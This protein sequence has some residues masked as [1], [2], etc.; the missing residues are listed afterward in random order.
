MADVMHRTWV[1]RLPSGLL[2]ARPSNRG[3]GA[4]TGTPLGSTVGWVTLAWAMP[5]RGTARADHRAIERRARPAP[6]ARA[7]PRCGSARFA[8]TG[9]RKNFGSGS[10]ARLG[11]GFEFDRRGDSSPGQLTE[12]FVVSDQRPADQPTILAT[13]LRPCEPGRAPAS[14]C[15]G[16][17]NAPQETRISGDSRH[18]DCSVPNP[19]PPLS[20]EHTIPLTAFHHILLGFNFNPLSNID[21]FTCNCRGRCHRRGTPNACAPHNP[22]GPRNCGSMSKRTAPR[23]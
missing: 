3:S 20:Y 7:T 13:P 16:P 21:E 12:I 19:G 18:P 10:P 17:I 1:I 4:G 5:I 14:T 23:A 11:E 15:I 22:A 8:R 6:S 2:H 9:R